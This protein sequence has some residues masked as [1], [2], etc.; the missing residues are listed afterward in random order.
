MFP[1]SFLTNDLQFVSVLEKQ[2]SNMLVSQLLMSLEGSLNFLCRFY[3]VLFTVVV[4]KLE[5]NSL[6]NSQ[7]E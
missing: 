3:L 2:F 7:H 5:L 4:I 6:M 1:I